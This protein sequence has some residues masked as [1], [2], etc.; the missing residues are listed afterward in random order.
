[1]AAPYDVYLYVWWVKM[2]CWY[3]RSLSSDGRAFSFWE[4][5]FIKKGYLKMKPPE[6]DCNALTI[7]IHL[8]LLYFL[9]HRVLIWL[10]DFFDVSYYVNESCQG[11][12]RLSLNADWLS[13]GVRGMSGRLESSARAL[14]RLVWQRLDL[15]GKSS[16]SDDRF[17]L[18]QQHVFCCLKKIL[19]WRPFFCVNGYKT[20]NFWE[21]VK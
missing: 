20:T 10:I 4:S 3:L 5:L 7:Y 11:Q 1:M 16:L 18:S 21:F 2:F 9:L 13:P 12:Q 19:A 15:S 8:L 17:V 6:E 14:A